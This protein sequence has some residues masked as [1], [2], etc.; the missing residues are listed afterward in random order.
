MLDLVVRGGTV[1]TSGGAFAAD[2]GIQNGRFA[3]I[4]SA[5]ELFG[6]GHFDAAGLHVL[7]G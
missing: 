3:A 7:P 6:E 4:A 2:L 5:G 1:V